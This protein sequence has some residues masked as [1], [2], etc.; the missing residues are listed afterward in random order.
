MVLIEAR[1]RGGSLEAGR[2]SVSMGVPLFAA[3]YEGMPDSAQG[4]RLLLGE[5]ARQ[6]FK[7]RNAGRA[8]IGPILEAIR[9]GQM[10]ER[11]SAAG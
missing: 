5:G 11:R 3:V 1:E 9:P 4:N 8:N 6:L 10:Q 2:A 7:S